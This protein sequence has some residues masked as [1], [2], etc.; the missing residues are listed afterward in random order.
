MKFLDFVSVRLAF[1][2]VLGILI[3]YYWP[4]NILWLGIVVLLAM[5]VLGSI[6]FRLK[7]TKVP[8][9]GIA[10][11]LTMTL[12]GMFTVARSHP[13]N[14]SAH[15]SRISSKTDG[16]LQLKIQ[17][18]LTSS[19]YSQRYVVRV[20]SVNGHPT[21]GKSILSIGIHANLTTL[22]VDDEIV[23]YGTATTVPPP[24]NPNQFNYQEYLRRQGIYHQINVHSKG[25]RKTKR[26]SKTVAG[27]ASRFREHLISKLRTYD[28]GAA[29]LGVIQAL[30]LGQR[31]DIPEDTYTSYK[32]AGAVHILAVSGLHIG[33]LL[34]IFQFLLRPLEQLPYGR[35]LTLIVVV[36]LLWMYAVLAGLSPSV[37]RAVTMFSF[38]AYALY[39]NR[40]TN[41]FNIITLSL[42]FILL[43][44]P[45]FLFQ[46]GFQMSYAAVFSIV[47][48]YPKLQSFWYPKNSVVRKTWQLLSVSIA[49]QL[50]VLPI[51]LFYFH[52]FPSLFFISNLL[53]VPFLGILL[54]AGLLLLVLAY[55]D[56]LPKMVL[57]GYNEA[58]GVM[59][60]VVSWIGEQEAFVFRD[61][62]FDI[63]QLAL[64]YLLIFGL[65]FTFT[66]SSFRNLVFLLCAIIGL[67][68]YSIVKDVIAKQDERLLL[69]HQNR[70]TVI[71]YQNGRTLQVFAE[72]TTRSKP[73]L[74]N[75][76]IARRIDTV[77]SRTLQNSY[78]LNT[79][80][81]IILDSAAVLPNTVRQPDYLLLT[82]SPRINLTRVIETLQPKMILADGSNYTS[83]VT[84]WK[85]TCL[86]KEIPFHYTGKD[87]YYKFPN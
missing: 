84:R 34:L 72:D 44:H 3:G 28:F 60:A 35:S 56:I 46:V 74:T 71:L 54:G 59:N 25:F 11:A 79:N 38:I 5:A 75:Y 55:F 9:F 16:Q 83:Y 47:W 48:I 77:V 67:F 1:W 32:D 52:Q 85:Q 22:S 23:L 61:I 2:L 82:Q 17:E 57:Y 65:V 86:E 64:G 70:N 37:V 80:Q 33:I 50:G 41:T 45:L 43:I 58:V 29:Q 12:I 15:F 19:P 6:R 36:I 26:P 21:T 40:P 27:R 4:L 69:V 13:R 24:L 18:V 20:L 62:P 81:L 78:S 73:L 76:K 30:L 63:A 14:H 87:G 7:T 10:L 31:N 39:L 68:S 42:V 49:A 53:I 8:V 51:S 66:K